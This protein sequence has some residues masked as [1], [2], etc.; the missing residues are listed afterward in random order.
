MKTHSKTSFLL[1]VLIAALGLIL[2]GRVSARTFTPLHKF[3]GSDGNAPNAGLILSGNTL[4]GTTING[5]TAA[6]GAVFRVNT[7]G[8]AFTNLHSFT[9]LSGSA[10]T[11]E[12]GANP[13][14]GLILSGNTLYGAAFAGGFAG[15]GTVF[16]V[17]TDGSTRSE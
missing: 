17:N 15:N 5:G 4:Y 1:P 12:D 9:A 3:S 13:Y 11:N 8:T 14:A 16:A 6:I 2:A 10:S 7:D